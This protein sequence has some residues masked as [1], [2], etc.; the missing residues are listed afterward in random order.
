MT[1]K[2]FI[3]SLRVG[4]VKKFA[5]RLGVSP[6]YLSQMASGRAAISPT[7]ALMIESAT[8]GQV[9]RAELR[10]HDWELIWP[11]YASGIRLGQTHVVHADQA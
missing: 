10:P 6:S 9:S 11:E 5:A 7:R 8:E 1:L 4:D 3:K 2:E